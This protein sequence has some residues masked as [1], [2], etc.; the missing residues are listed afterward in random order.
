LGEIVLKVRSISRRPLLD[1]ASLELRAGEIVALAGL[2]GSGRSEFARAL[3]GLSRTDGGIIE[4]KGKPVKFTSL[5]EAMAHGFAYVPSERKSEGLFL[6]LSTA[7]NI[8]AARFTRLARFGVTN[9]EAK[10]ALARG[11]IDR[12]GIRLRNP[13][14]PVG[15]LSGGNQQK[16]LL[17]KWLAIRPKVLVVE[18]PT[19]GVDV[20]AKYEIHRVLRE[21]ARAGTAI[22]VVSSDVPEILSLAQRI[23]VLR[24]GRTIAQFAAERASEERVMALMSGVEDMSGRTPA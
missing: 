18:E 22:L 2:M 9:R 16:V 6:D 21:L 12:L 5:S 14:D 8:A 7:D 3:C 1:E 4:L 10:A 23:A 24:Q 11:F 15:R 13:D 20:V 19:R 17:A